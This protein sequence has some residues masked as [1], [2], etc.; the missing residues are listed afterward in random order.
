[1]SRWL[2]VALVIIQVVGL[3]S[4]VLV[5][6]W[7]ASPDERKR[8]WAKWSGLIVAAAILSALI[9]NGFST[10]D[11]LKRIGEEPKQVP[12][13]EEQE[14]MFRRILHEGKLES[15]DYKRFN[16]DIRIVDLFFAPESEPADPLARDLTSLLSETHKQALRMVAD[17]LKHYDR[18][19]L[20]IQG[21]A[22]F[23]GKEEYSLALGSRRAQMVKDF[24]VKEGIK[25]SR[26][27]TLSVGGEQLVVRNRSPEA[28]RLNNRVHF[29][30]CPDTCERP[31][32]KQIKP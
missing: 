1:M 21:R 12:T 27:S 10:Y 23:P 20:M 26:I 22:Y 25:R 16:P 8:R 24:L 2:I 6:V 4:A 32:T 14:S 9:P 3:I 17:I 11:Q 5:A 29:V 31:P 19:A 28:L 15:A 18:T 30:F 13:I 7:S